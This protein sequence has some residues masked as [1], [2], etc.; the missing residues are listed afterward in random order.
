MKIG[1][2][3]LGSMGSAI[4]TNLIEAGHDVKVYNRNPERAAPLRQAG[5]TVAVTPSQAAQAADAVFT[6]VAD[7]AALA[8][9]THGEA[10]I[11]SGMRPGAVHVSMST[12]SLAAAQ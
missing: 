3:G 9:V 2:V 4:A 8:A 5:A 1:F 10:G 6:M 7:A 12:I 11:A